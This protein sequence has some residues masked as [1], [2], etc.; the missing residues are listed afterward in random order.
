MGG[1]RDLERSH[2]FVEEWR[3]RVIEMM[4]EGGRGI[5]NVDS[6]AG[7]K[8]VMFEIGEEGVKRWEVD[9]S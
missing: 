5:V 8:G 2:M 1:L 3:E 9:V 4:I 6:G 7:G